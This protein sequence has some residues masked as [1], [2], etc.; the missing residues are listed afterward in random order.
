MVSPGGYRSGNEESISAGSASGR[1]PRGDPVAAICLLVAAIDLLDPLA[2]QAQ[3]PVET[4][5]LHPLDRWI[6]VGQSLQDPHVEADLV[7]ELALHQPLEQA[8]AAVLAGVARLRE[9][10]RE[11]G[12]VAIIDRH[13]EYVQPPADHALPARLRTLPPVVVDRVDR[14]EVGRPVV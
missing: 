5:Q 11:E 3:H 9:R 13:E 7:I 14:R 8:H 2:I 10:E 1:L 6:L 12:G 4:A